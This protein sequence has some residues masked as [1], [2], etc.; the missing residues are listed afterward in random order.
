MQQVKKMSRIPY[1]RARITAD[2]SPR[3]LRGALWRTQ[4]HLDGAVF[5]E[6]QELVRRSLKTWRP[7]RSPRSPRDCLVRMA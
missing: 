6:E 7:E 4:V 5:D 1:A 3:R 2:R